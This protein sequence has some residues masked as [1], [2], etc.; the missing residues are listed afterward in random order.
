MKTKIVLS[1]LSVITCF[2]VTI[3]ASFAWY[4]VT[5]ENKTGS[6]S[7][8]IYEADCNYKLY[9]YSNSSWNFVSTTKI[10][11]DNFTPTN[12][13]YFRLDVIGISNKDISVSVFL[14]DIVSSLSSE[15]L[16]DSIDDAVYV[17]DNDNNN[18]VLYTATSG[19]VNVND[20]VLYDCS[21][22]ATILLKDYLIEDV[23]TLYSL[24]SS[25]PTLTNATSL[26]L[27]DFIVSDVTISFGETYSIY[28]ALEFNDTRCV[29]NSVNYAYCYQYQT[30]SVCPVIRLS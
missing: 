18:L 19:Y 17:T 25:I 16:Y 22:D 21:D 2:I 23:V 13:E 29:D 9:N 12:V 4:T 1:L 14:T 3:V 30:F 10:E 20:K 24:D 11:I 5:T 28:F 27:E 7:S 15:L 26:G 8:G 6:T